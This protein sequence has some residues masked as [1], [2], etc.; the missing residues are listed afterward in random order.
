MNLLPEPLGSTEQQR[1]ELQERIE[2][3]LAAVAAGQRVVEERAFC[4]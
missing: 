4:A 3:L 1:Y 2:R